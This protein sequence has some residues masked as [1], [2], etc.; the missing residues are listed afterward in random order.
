VSTGGDCYIGEDC[1][2]GSCDRGACDPST[3]CCEGTCAAPTTLIAHGAAC[4]PN[5]SCV[6]SDE[7]IDG[8]CSTWTIPDGQ[9]CGGGA[10]RCVDGDA[11]AADVF[12]DLICMK[13]VERGDACVIGAVCDHG[14][15]CDDDGSSST[16][17]PLVAVGGSCADSDPCVV[18]ASCDPTTSK[19]VTNA[20]LG[21]DCSSTPCLGDATCD[22]TTSKCTP[23]VSADCPQ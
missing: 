15:Y 13:I 12:G 20:L 18:Y 19:C 22:P 21:Q 11:C 5:D 2:S 10:G 7:C 6:P 17:K 9:D 23:A 8:T 3:G 1:V 14:L 16:C 4:T